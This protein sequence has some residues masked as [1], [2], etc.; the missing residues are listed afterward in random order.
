MIGHF[1]ELPYTL[2]QDCTLF[3]VLGESSPQIWLEKLD[4]IE[5]HYGMGLLNTHPDYLTD[6]K[7]WNIYVDFLETMKERDGYW[8]AL[9]S[10]V[11]RWW[12]GR[13]ATQ[14]GQ[15]LPEMTIN[16][17]IRNGHEISLSLSLST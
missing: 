1:V 15:E 5:R 8:Q 10:K 13:A 16:T 17:I 11:A 2:P 4:F 7:I 3:I 6:P 14:I 12:R 9:P